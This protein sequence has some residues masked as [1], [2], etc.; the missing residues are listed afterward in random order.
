MASS[1][2]QIIDKQTHDKVVD[3]SER[4]P[5]IIYVSNY[6]LPICREFTPQYE[7]LAQKHSK[8]QSVVNFCQMEITSETSAMFKFSPNQLPVLVLMCRGPWSKTMMSPKIGQL[9]T[10]IER[11]LER[12]GRL[13]N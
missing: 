6:A 2:T 10:E 5:T 1:I 7:D 13:S 8:E 9:D 12:V 4:T 3:E 11:M